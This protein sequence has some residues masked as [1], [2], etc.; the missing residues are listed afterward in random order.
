MVKSFIDHNV[1]DEVGR[2]ERFE[3][4][5]VEIC[6]SGLCCKIYAYILFYMPRVP[7]QF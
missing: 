4:N 7:T 1:R 6:R 3:A 5:E 2:L